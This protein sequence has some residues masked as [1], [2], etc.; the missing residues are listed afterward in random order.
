MP[1]YSRICW[2]TLRS[3]K[4]KWGYDMAV[5][6]EEVKKL[7]WERGLKVTRQRIMVLEAIASCPEEHLTAEEIFELV[8]VDCPEI[9]L[10]T[11]Y[12]TIQLLSEL[13]LIDRISFDDGFVRYEMGSAPN[14]KQKH[15]HHHLICMKCGK[16]ISFQDDLLEELEAKI[17][18]TTGFRVVDHEVK[19]YGYC[20]EC[21]GDLIEE[22]SE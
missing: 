7:L 8:K 11:V 17:A 2:M 12:R 1:E 5:D 21:G 9:G 4:R 20:V 16:V 19:L 6:R 13:R 15:H 14:Q 18:V 3:R 22:K 10:A